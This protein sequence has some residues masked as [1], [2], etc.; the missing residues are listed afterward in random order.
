MFSGTIVHGL[1][2]GSLFG[3]IFGVTFPGCVYLQ[4]GFKV[5]KYR[6]GGRAGGRLGKR[7]ALAF[8]SHINLLHRLFKYFFLSS[9]P[10][11]YIQF[12][13]PVYVGK[14]VTALVSTPRCPLSLPLS[15]LK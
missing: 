12:S 3:T 8:P 7:E 6:E 5:R 11:F 13:R 15:L 4:Q 1:L 9:S 2:V 14:P 10:A